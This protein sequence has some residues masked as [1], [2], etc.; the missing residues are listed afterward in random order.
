MII[1]IKKI[2]DDRW[3]IAQKSER[4]F[5]EGYT[6]QFF[7]EEK[8]NHKRKAEILEKEWKDMG[9]ITFNKNT[10]ILQVGCGPED[11]IN[12]LPNGEKFAI[13][14]LA[15]FYKQRFKVN[16]KDVNFVEGRGENL[17]FKYNFFDMVI[18]TNVLDHVEAPK[19]VLSELNRVLKK[20]GILY[21]E[22]FV[23][24]KNFIRTAKIYGKIKEL[25]TK[26]IFNI[27]HPYMFLKEEVKQLVEERFSI[28]KEEIGREIFA[29]IKDMDDLKLK[30]KKSKR[31]N[32]RFPAYLGLYG[33]INYTII[34]KKV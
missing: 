4:R 11:I 16:Y 5:W 23:Y 20:N 26:E 9:I 13:D 10:K 2:A 34:G 15:N 30:T 6:D 24:Q 3:G 14:P 22:I 18:L 17:P 7:E 27:H 29:G 33:I 28:E 8:M 31:F 25:I 1:E 21:F 32:V 19:K 12:Y